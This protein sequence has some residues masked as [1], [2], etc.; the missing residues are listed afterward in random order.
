MRI[1]EVNNN[2]EYQKE[3]LMLPVR[4]YQGNPYW[5]RPIDKDVE[6]TFNPEKNKNF[7]NGQ[8]T[9][10][11][12]VD[13]TGQTVG[14]V[15]AFINQ[16]T[17]S[18]GNDQPTGGMGFFECI[19][20]E[21]VAFALF[22][23]CKNWLAE[24]EIEAMDGPIN[25]GDRDR[26][27]GLLTD[28]F[29]KEPLYGM[30]YHFSYYGNFFEKYGFEVYFYQHTFFLYMTK[31]KFM[32]RVNKVFFD[33]AERILSMPNYEFRHIEKKK[34]PQ[35]AD[36][37]RQ[38]Y[39]KAWAKNLGTEDI[40][41]E[42]A[43]A[44]MERMKPIM[45]EELMW[46]GYHQGEPIAFFIMLPELNQI[47]K[48]VNGKLNLLGKIKFLYHKLLKTNHKAFGV[49]FGV[50][51]EFQGRGVE[52]AIALASSRVA[53][54]PNY[55]YTEMEFNWIGDFNPKMI[56][57]CELLGGIPHKQHATYRYLFDRA[58]AFKRHPM[59]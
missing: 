23:T 41:P 9:R 10:W 59:I 35:Y 39:N 54:R 7:K 42:K 55:Q 56:R 11:I 2:R 21:T 34:L 17:V 31:E 44:L 30:G 47:F 6:D 8:C 51:P 27:W 26:F 29:D 49:I 32:E 20:D 24:R 36:D 28:G 45:D 48:Y 19:E 3:F 22:D 43:R 15:A 33:R 50:V 16:N 14:R 57:F 46:F 13:D 40:T 25:F 52:S 58:K 12:A 53:W 5:I 18:K 1:I 37:F 4:L 38:I